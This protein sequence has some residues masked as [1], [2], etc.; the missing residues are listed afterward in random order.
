MNEVTIRAAHDDERDRVL[1][2][3]DWL[4]EPPGYTP[5]WWD[6]TRARQALGEAIRAE[7]STVLVA[8]SGVAELVGIAS[9]YLDLN[10]VR[11]GP[12][13]WGED[14]A[15]DPSRHSAGVGQ[16]LLDAAKTWARERGATHLELD[17]GLGRSDAQRFYDR[18]EPTA[19]GFSY[20]WAL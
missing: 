13:A 15:V 1:E 6:A 20:S 3:Y 19:K 17:T 16:A 12:R 14:L 8:Q 4:F 7:S 18:E 9:V 10:S 5:R 2:M 11:F